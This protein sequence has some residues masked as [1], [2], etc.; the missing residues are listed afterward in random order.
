MTFAEILAAANETK[1]GR[2][3][4]QWTPAACKTWREADPEMARMLEAAFAWELGNGR[5]ARP[6]DEAAVRA[7]RKAMDEATA[8][9]RAGSGGGG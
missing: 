1:T 4:G 9:A 5:I 8:A 6:E 2:N 7:V 3:P